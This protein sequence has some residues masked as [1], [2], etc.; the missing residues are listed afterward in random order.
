MED[1]NLVRIRI[2]W[3]DDLGMELGD[4]WDSAL[5]RVN[6]SSSCARLA[7]IQFKVL[8]RVHYSKAKLAEIYPGADASCAR[9]SFSPANL[10]HSFWSCPSLETYWS[11]VFKTLSE[12]LNIPIE[13]NPLTAIFG[14]PADAVTKTQSDVIAF[15]SLLARRRILLGWKSSTPPSLA[16]WMEDIMLF[17]KLEKIKF[18][19]RGSMKNFYLRWQPIITY[20]D[21]LKDLEAD[22]TQH[23][24]V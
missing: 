23:E 2:K 11:G 21:N 18:T 7:L 24:G 14:I 12:A 17:L 1:H 19:L 20:F 6:S 13:S 15:T 5:T 3:E 9:C 10:T 8:H 4:Y 22:P 16:R